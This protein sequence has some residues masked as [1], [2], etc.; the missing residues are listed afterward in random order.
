MACAATLL[1]IAERAAG[2]GNATTIQ[3]H[4]PARRYFRVRTRAQ[5]CCPVYFG[6]SLERV[7]GLDH[8]GGPFD[9]ERRARLACGNAKRQ[10]PQESIGAGAGDAKGRG[11]VAESQP[12]AVK[13]SAHPDSTALPG[14]IGFA[15]AFSA[16]ITTSCRD[17]MA[18]IITRIRHHNGT[19]L[20]IQI[21]PFAIGAKLAARLSIRGLRSVSFQRVLV[22]SLVRAYCHACGKCSP[23][24]EAL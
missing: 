23:Q 7:R 21:R 11:R 14:A 3:I 8:V 24:K 1:H 17:A 5:W 16:L 18:H 10:E 13:P 6:R 4:S 20:R 15:L 12:A 19:S 22:A 9:S 2:S